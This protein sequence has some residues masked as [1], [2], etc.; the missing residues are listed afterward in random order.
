M[1]NRRALLRTGSLAAAAA[2]LGPSAAWAEIGAPAYLAA[3]KESSGAHHL[4]GLD[5]DGRELF[6]LPLPGRG[7]AAA[8]HPTRVEAVAF[9]RRPGHYALVIDCAEGRETAR[10]AA[11][12][13]RRF[14]GHG[15]FSADGALLYTTENAYEIGEGRIG[16]WD[17]ADG[18]RRIGEMASGGVGPHD[19]TLSPDGARL[20]VANGGLQTHPESGRAIL[21]L[22]DMR[23]NLS[24][25]DASSGALLTMFEPPAQWRMSS[26]R[27][28]AQRADGL[29][30]AALQW[31]GGPLETPPLLALA[32]PGADA[33]SFHAA[34][35]DLQRRTRGYAGSVAFSG[36]GS[37]VAFTAPKGGLALSF[38]AETGA[39]VDS[40]FA[41]DVCGAAAAA[42]GFLFTTGEGRV[43]AFCGGAAEERSVATGAYDN[44]LVAL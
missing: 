40:V 44:H 6:R 9:E 32:R 2:A 23:P 28:L 5:A 30:A 34:P 8:A 17:A 36:D 14:Y 15:V 7:H 10:L 31:Q 16:V 42:E 38:D 3:T 20:I 41:S 43:L 27:H 25:L 33:L 21:N 29:I 35:T 1:L 11:P 18:Y 39:H 4:V 13:G 12:E 37:Q 26:I 24:M 22:P 19:A